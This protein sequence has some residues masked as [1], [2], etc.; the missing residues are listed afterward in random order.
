MS[1]IRGKSGVPTGQL[2]PFVGQERG[3]ERGKKGE[4]EEIK[5]RDVRKGKERKM[6]WVKRGIRAPCGAVYPEEHREER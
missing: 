5:S 4:N 3:E 6:D 2:L 1:R